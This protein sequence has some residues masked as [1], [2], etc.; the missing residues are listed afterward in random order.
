[1]RRS[2]V[3]SLRPGVWLLH[4]KTALKRADLACVSSVR[5]GQSRTLRRHLAAIPRELV[6][7]SDWSIATIISALTVQRL[8]PNCSWTVGKPDHDILVPRRARAIN[9]R[10]C[11]RTWRFVKPYVLQRS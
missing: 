1:M 5:I 6:A 3:D 9:V 11:L 10:F 7:L 8:V 4:C 2:N